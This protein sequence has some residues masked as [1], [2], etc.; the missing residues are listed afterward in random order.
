MPGIQIRVFGKPKGIQGNFVAGIRM[1]LFPVEGNGKT[2]VPFDKNVNVGLDFL[3]F[4]SGLH[5]G[6][7][8][9]LIELGI[10]QETMSRERRS[11]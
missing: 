6:V 4:S 3:L 8:A 10:G 2:C 11:R 9:G 5:M 1:G 7:K